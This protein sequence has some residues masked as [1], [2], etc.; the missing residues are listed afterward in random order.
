MKNFYQHSSCQHLEQHLPC[1]YFKLRFIIL[2][3][4]ITIKVILLHFVMFL[5]L[6]IHV[7]SP[8]LYGRKKLKQER[9]LKISK[10]IFKAAHYPSTSRQVTAS[11]H[12]FI[13]NAPRLLNT[14]VPIVTCACKVRCH[15]Q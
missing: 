9:T 12:P 4:H 3:I 5:Q 1:P 10:L 15:S 8:Q 14:V 2:V 11:S 6:P 7:L 13:S